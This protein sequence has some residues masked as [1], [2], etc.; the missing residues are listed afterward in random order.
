MQNKY[1]NNNPYAETQ[2]NSSNPRQTEARALLEAARKLSDAKDAKNED[3][4]INKESF[5]G[6]LR[7]NW[8]LWTILQADMMDEDNPL[9]NELKAN[10]L[11][12]SGFIDKRT[13]SSLSDLKP[14]TQKLD[15]LISINRNIAAGLLS[16]TETGQSPDAPLQTDNK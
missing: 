15:I 2:N 12:L 7:F 16:N 4:S 13:V 6:A 1:P 5:E 14:N 11:N 9:P 8:K 10:L 3:G